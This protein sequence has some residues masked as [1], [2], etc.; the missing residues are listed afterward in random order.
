M[1]EE[2]K[3]ERKEKRQKGKKKHGNKK[4]TV[5]IPPKPSCSL[6]AKNYKRKQERRGG[7]LNAGAG[8]ISDEKGDPRSKG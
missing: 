3:K 7:E 6:I 8:V 4:Q 2:E 5:S 1:K